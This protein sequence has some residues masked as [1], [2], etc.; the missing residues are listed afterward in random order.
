MPIGIDQ[1]SPFFAALDAALIYEARDMEKWHTQ[2]T[3]AMLHTIQSLNAL[4][5]LR[6]ALGMDIA[7]EC[8]WPKKA[9]VLVTMLFGT[10]WLVEIN[11]ELHLGPAWDD[12]VIKG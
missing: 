8:M 2:S 12:A 7:C 6:K 3:V 10:G 1:S 9:D 4:G 5:Q 11:S